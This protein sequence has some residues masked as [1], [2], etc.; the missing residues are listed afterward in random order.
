[1]GAAL[2]FL[3]KYWMI[4]MALTRSFFANA[5]CSSKT[6]YSLLTPTYR[7]IS[8]SV[9]LVAPGQVDQQLVYLVVDPAQIVADMIHQQQQ[10]LLRDLI[11]L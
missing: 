8:S 6:L 5:S 7:S 10:R 3:S 2:G 9:I 11:P 1:M 4:R